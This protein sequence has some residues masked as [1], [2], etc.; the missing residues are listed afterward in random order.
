MHAVFSVNLITC[1]PVTPSSY[2]SSNNHC[3]WR[4]LPGASNHVRMEEAT[5][6]NDGMDGDRGNGDDCGKGSNVL[7]DDG[8]KSDHSSD[9]EWQADEWRDDDDG[10]RVANTQPHDE[11]DSSSSSGLH[12]EVEV[13][14]HS[15]EAPNYALT[16][17]CQGPQDTSEA[18]VIESSGTCTIAL[19]CA[20]H[21]LAR[22]HDLSP[23]F[24]F[25]V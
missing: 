2:L 10:F 14:D 17:F 1:S 15:I 9:V 11:H 23:S 16:A 19:R 24:L 12:R 4:V 3:T 22:S 21:C 13:Q 6:Q 18:P 25:R 7:E 20:Y 8:R 5:E